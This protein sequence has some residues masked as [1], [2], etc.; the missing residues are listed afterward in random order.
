MIYVKVCIMTEFYMI[1]TPLNYPQVIF[2]K[3]KIKKGTKMSLEV[4]H[5]KELNKGPLV[6]TFTIRLLKLG[7]EIRECTEWNKNGKRWISLPSR[8]YEQNGEKKYFSICY[9]YER[10]NQGVFEKH[11][12]EALDKAKAT[13]IPPTQ[14]QTTV[15]QTN[16]IGGQTAKQASTQPYVKPV[17]MQFQQQVQDE[18]LPF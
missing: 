4:T 13:Y 10:E 9:F 15:G 11:A 3:K 14:N 2:T 18:E 1:M 7:L 16:G 17:Q 5:Y 6:S 8:Q 12:L